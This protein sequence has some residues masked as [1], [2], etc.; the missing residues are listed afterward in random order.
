[1]LHLNRL[2]AFREVVR[3]GTF[4][5][6]ADVLGYSQPAISH[7]IAQLEL[8]V[9]AK[10]L[11][12]LPRGGVTLTEA[13]KLLLGHAD[14]LL[15]LATD[16]ESELW[17]MIKEGQVRVRLGAFATASA[18]IVADAIARVRRACPEVSI[19]LIEGEASETISLLKTRDIDIAVVFDDP[20]H[21]VPEDDTVELRYLYEDPLLVAMPR[22]HRLAR[23]P[24]VDL[25]EL[26]DEDWIEGAAKDTPCSLILVATCEELG[27]EPRIAFNS[28]NYQVVQRLVA[29]GLGVALVPELAI[30]G[31][32]PEIV[33]RPLWPRS[34]S[35][36]IG[37]ALRRA[38]YRSEALLAVVAELER[39]FKAYAAQQPVHMVDAAS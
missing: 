19:T 27:Y 24:V 4:S 31:A 32:D 11:E 8:A 7:N 38:G 18:T 36:R 5:A 25:S 20:Q 14:R 3:Q 12:R 34:P 23:T 33:I 26:R 28:G 39:T 29:A 13:G 17:E 30:T 10:L 35:R 22:R 21:A 2:R 1:M 16:A 15:D 37:V 6:A 9:G